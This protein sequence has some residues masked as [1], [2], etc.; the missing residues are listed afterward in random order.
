MN[1]CNQG[2]KNKKQFNMNFLKKLSKHWCKILFVFV[3]LGIA[4]A[5]Y[6]KIETKGSE[7]VLPECKYLVEDLKVYTGDYYK[8][9]HYVAFNGI[10]RNLSN[11]RQFLNAVIAKVYDKNNVLISDGGSNNSDW[12]EPGKAIPFKVDT[13]YSGDSINQSE[14]NPDIYPWFITCK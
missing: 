2:F 9:S 13:Q 11:K 5:A 4:F 7:H 10:I 14:M 8:Q 6:Q 12:I 1:G 3:I